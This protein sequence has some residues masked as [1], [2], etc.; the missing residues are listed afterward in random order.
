MRTAILSN[1]KY[2]GI[3]LIIR[4]SG[5][6]LQAHNPE[7]EEAEE[8]LEVSYSGD[9][10]EIGFHVNYLL[11]AIGAVGLARMFMFGGAYRQPLWHPSVR[12]G[13]WEHG[14]LGSSSYNHL[15]E[16]LLK[17]KDTM[18]TASGRRL[19]EG[20]HRFMEQFAARFEREWVGEA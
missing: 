9:D 11:D 12:P 16:K 8:E 10:I 4:G 20:R 6:V 17:L 15:H 14:N 5:L 13:H 7:Q 19:A 1:E 3:R 2:R 18:N